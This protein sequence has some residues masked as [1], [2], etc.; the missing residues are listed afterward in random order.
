[1]KVQTKARVTITRMADSSRDS[2]ALAAESWCV[3]KTAGRPAFVSA[4]LHGAW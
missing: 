3:A 2:C 1:M 4:L